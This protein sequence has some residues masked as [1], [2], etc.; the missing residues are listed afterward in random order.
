MTVLNIDIDKQL[1]EFLL[2]VKIECAGPVTGLFGPS[3]AGKTSILNLVA[4]LLKPD[5]GTI[6]LDGETLDDAG[7]KRHVPAHQ[8]HI[9]YVFQDAR[10]FPHLSVRQNLDYGRRMNGLQPD[11]SGEKRAIEMLGIGD[12]LN[13]RPAQLSGGERQRIALGRALFAKPKLMLLDEPIGSLDDERKAEVLPLLIR[14]RDEAKVPMVY[15][16]HDAAE[17]RRLATSVVVL[18]RGQVVAQGGVDILP[19]QTI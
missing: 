8:R 3:G 5:R 2:S 15:V 16:S 14:L 9:G 12:L 1:G 10:L 13:R 19:V 18:K 7:S 17:L 11:V 4:G 6:V